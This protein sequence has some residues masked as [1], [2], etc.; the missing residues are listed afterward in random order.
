MLHIL[1][2][3]QSQTNQHHWQEFWFLL[4][5]VKWRLM[6]PL[7]PQ[8]QNSLF[9]THLHLRHRNH[10][11][12]CQVV[13]IRASHPQVLGRSYYTVRRPHF[14]VSTAT[15][16]L[17]KKQ[18]PQIEQLRQRQPLRLTHDS[19]AHQSECFIQKSIKQTNTRCVDTFVGF[20][21]RRGL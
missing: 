6:S 13:Y 5:C 18:F 12:I 14:Q 21:R 20:N 11:A 1:R 3:S 9:P 8:T 2:C 15:R 17:T 10:L 16:R 19:T 7:K 4:V